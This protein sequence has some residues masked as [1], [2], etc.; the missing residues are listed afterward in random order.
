MT[1]TDRHHTTLVLPTYNAADFIADTVA[2]LRRFVAEHPGWRCLFVLDGCRDDTAARLEALL[3][4]A[5]PDL[6]AHVYTVNRGKGHALRTGLDIAAGWTPYLVYTDVDLAYDPDEA[7][8]VQARL[9]EGAD[10]A[11]VNRADPA[12]RFWISPTDFPTLYKRHLMSRSFN[13]LVRQLLPITIGDT[14]AGLK[15]ITSAAWRRLAPRMTTDGFFFDVEF[16][17]R[18]GAEGLRAA[19]T[20]V[21]FRYVAPTTVRMVKHATSMFFDVLRLRKQLKRERRAR[22]TAGHAEPCRAG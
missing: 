18:A 8:K 9:V 16:L 20:P 21:V 22:E 15:G 10:L 5:G 14:Q 17:A 6:T 4:G 19:E 2:R 1:A 7:V 3:A 12:S 11:V 13:W